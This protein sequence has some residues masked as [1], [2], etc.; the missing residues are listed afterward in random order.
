MEPWELTDV[1]WEALQSILQRSGGARR[2]RGRPRL[3]NDRDAARACLFRHYHSLS[4]GYHSFGWNELPREFGISPSTANRRFREWTADGSWPRFWDALM[5]LRHGS[6]PRSRRRASHRADDLPVSGILGELERAYRYFNAR[7]FGGSLPSSVAIILQVSNPNGKELGS[8]CGQEW[9]SENLILDRI[10]IS[11][12]ALGCGP[13]LVLGVLL[14]EMVHQRNYGLGLVDCTDLGRYH[15][16]TFRDTACLAG[17]ECS[18]TADRHHGYQ[19]TRPGARAL[20]AIS[21]L[22][23]HKPSFEWHA[24]LELSGGDD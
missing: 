10:C 4:E 5:E 13:E 15:N 6:P 24:G 1:E 3:E 18:P 22:R 7:F 16:R 8:F 9:R 23:P 2:D 21:Q 20:A 11:S 19:A 14:H 12:S 17:L